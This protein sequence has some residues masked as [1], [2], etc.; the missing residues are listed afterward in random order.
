M[1]LIHIQSSLYSTIVHS[2]S[3][4][5]IISYTCIRMDHTSYSRKYT[6][7]YSWTGNGLSV[8]SKPVNRLRI[9][10]KYRKFKTNVPRYCEPTVSSFYGVKIAL[11][12][13]TNATFCTN[14]VEGMKGWWWFRK[15][16][17]SKETFIT[18]GFILYSCANVGVHTPCNE[19]RATNAPWRIKSQAY[20]NQWQ[21]YTFLLKER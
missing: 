1:Q 3:I 6:S 18:P 20:L 4:H 11:N 17:R 12:Y 13:R 21:K 10:L 15:E 8:P 16:S 14:P 2:L 7:L 5:C 19:K 9:F